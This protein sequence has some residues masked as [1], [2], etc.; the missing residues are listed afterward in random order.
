MALRSFLFQSAEGFADSALPTDET[1]LGKLTL[2]GISGVAIDSGNA[3]IINVGDPSQPQD[4]ATKNYV[5]TIQSG[6]T[7]KAP[8]RVVSTTNVNIASAPAS[9]DGITL[10][11]GDRV[12]LVGQ[13]NA[14]ENG[15][16]VYPAAA[17]SAMTR[18]LDLDAT[19]EYVP[20]TYVFVNE[21]STQENSAWVVTND[22]A[23]VVGTTP[24]TWVQF[25]GLG[26][27]VAGAGLTSS[28]NTLDAGK[29]D[30]IAIGADTIA[31]DLDVNPALALNGTSP[32]KKLAFLPDLTR[33]LNK[34][35]AGAFV[36]LPLTNPG[37]LFDGSGNVDV[38][39]DANG[40]L[41]KDALGLGVK[42]GSSSELSKDGTGLHV[43]GLPSAFQI[44]GVATDGAFV[45]ASNLD[46]VL[47]GSNADAL[48]THTAAAEVP[49]VKEVWTAVGALAKGDGVYVSA[50]NSVSK[51]DATDDL[52]SRV[53]GVAEA[54]V[55]NGAQGK[56]VVTG[57]VTSVLS[58]ATPGD[59]YYMSAL[60]QPTLIGSLPSR[61]RTIQL[62][63][64]KNSTDLTVR[65]FDYGKKV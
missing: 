59:R 64:A 57:V 62:G 9:I 34:D 39:V 46:T 32:N 50:N 12:L 11:Q 6:L 53:I 35:S 23:I 16:Y 4:A 54:A 44:N 36:K 37:L 45:T 10:V 19:A 13:T 26:Q 8:A 56:V 17:G 52:K 55:A 31:I 22:T 63:I 48:H 27:I 43:V 40:G 47:N 42:I 65:V 2:S 60:G 5:D 30:G 28:G 24:V 18:A 38:K 20:G 1:Q 41:L 7:V 33:G 58:G 15:V 25:S 51:G 61:A 3:R 29:G 14:A 21:G 49:A